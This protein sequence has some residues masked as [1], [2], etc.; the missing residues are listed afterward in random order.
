MSSFLV[1]MYATM[2]KEKWFAFH[3]HYDGFIKGSSEYLIMTEK[4][5]QSHPPCAWEKYW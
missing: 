2:E 3:L 4:D 1:A 5:Q